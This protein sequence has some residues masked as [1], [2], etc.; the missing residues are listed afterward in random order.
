M[1]DFFDNIK[2]SKNGK[3]IVFFGVYLL[4]FIGIFCLIKFGGNKDY[5]TQKYERGNKGLYDN[6]GILSN[7][8]Y[9]NYKVKIDGVVHDYY[10]KKYDN[11]ELFKYNNHDYYRNVDNYYINNNENWS[12]VDRPYL[13]YEFIDI[14]NSGNLLDD[15]YLLST[16]KSGDMVKSYTYLVSSNSINKFLYNIDSDYDEVPN[17]IIL[18]VDDKKN[19]NKI[20]FK[21]NSFCKLKNV[22]Q[23]DLEIELSYEMFGEV[24]KIDNPLN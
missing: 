2:D 12:K 7:N 22:C 16:N 8:Y 20:T 21:L 5:L 15:A 10:G 9:F 13:L 23:N 4:F 18:E 14:E 19:V 24:K 3:I 6:E 17:Q 1:K 11:V